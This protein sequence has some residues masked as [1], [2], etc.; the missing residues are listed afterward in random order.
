MNI[1]EHTAFKFWKN[2]VGDKNQD[3][4]CGTVIEA[5]LGMITHTNLEGEIFIIAGWLHDLGKII[6]KH[7]HHIESLRFLNEFLE[8]HKDY[9][10]WRCELEDCILNHRTGMKPKTLYGQIFQI[11][12]KV[13]LLNED[14]VNYKKKK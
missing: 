2:K 3:I 5:C 14:W 13:G 4:H 11:A 10:K 1:R 7:N 8:L 12:D 6:N 9:K